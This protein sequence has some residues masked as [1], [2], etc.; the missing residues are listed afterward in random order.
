MDIEKAIRLTRKYKAAKATEQD[1]QKALDKAHDYICLGYTLLNAADI[2]MR[3]TANVMSAVGPERRYED[4]FHI[5]DSM[6]DIQKVIRRTDIYSQHFDGLI[7]E[8]NPMAYDAMRNNAYEILR[9]VMLLYSRTCGNA[10][11]TKQLEAYMRHMKNNGLFSDDE[12]SS[13]KMK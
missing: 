13:F 6:K 7:S 12:I 5:C 11:A 9:F 4:T 3:E 10:K 8:E 1:R 2:I